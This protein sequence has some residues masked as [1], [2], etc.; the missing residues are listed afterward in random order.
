M[1]FQ[2]T[3]V[4][5]V[6]YHR[7]DTT[8]P[9]G[10]LAF[11]NRKIFFEYTSSFLGLGIE[12][13][14]FK[15]P[16]K[17]GVLSCEDR[18][19]DGLFG[20]FND[21]LSDGWGRLL[22]DRKLLKMGINSESLTPLDR[23]QFVG[24]HGMGALLYEPEI[25]EGTSHQ[26]LQKD[27][28]GIASEC[29]QMQ[30]HEEDRFVDELLMLN[31]SSAGARPKI[32]VSLMPNKQEFQIANNSNVSCSNWM[33][34][35]RSSLDPKD[36]GSIEYAYHLMAI[37][38]GLDVPEARLFKS[39]EHAGYFGVKRFDRQGSAFVHMHTLSGL[40][41][42]DHRI[43]S[44]DYE[45][46]MKATLWLTK[47]VRE[48]EKQFRNVVFNVLAHNRDDHAKNFSFLM[49]TNGS[50][51]VSPAYDL[52]FSSGPA[53]EHHSTI[54]GEGKNPTVSH[55]LKLAAIA[56]LQPQQALNIIDEVK[57]SVS[58]WS[59]FAK[60]AHVGTKSCSHIQKELARVLKYLA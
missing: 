20:V 16:T 51:R 43:P 59:D 14:P 45:T 18:V 54:M 36:V 21:S 9:V 26:L 10:R 41:H 23:L 39:K 42:I 56:S 53:G 13:S 17:P 48:C 3:N 11:L 46:L 27:L 19:F 34:K 37:D 1:S 35:F 2:Q 44:V 4:I 5:H 8:I 12:I 28:D 32:L 33:I 7:G 50:W 31:G 38:S 24:S 30:E 29:F 22:L 55:L 58:K 40:L 60:K 57:E 52:V 6:K 15:L 49:D 47:D 25:S